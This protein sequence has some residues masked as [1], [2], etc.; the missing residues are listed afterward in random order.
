[1]DL[2][3]ARRIV[4]EWLEEWKPPDLVPREAQ[5]PDLKKL[6]EILAIV[7]PRRAGKTYFMFQMLEDLVR[8]SVCARDDI[9]FIDFEDY[10]LADMTPAD[11]DLLF[12]AFNQLAGKPPRF[13]F[14]D[15]IQRLPSWSRVL[16]ALHNQRRYKIIVSGS[17]SEL[18]G[19]EVSTE[20]RGRY[21]DLL[22]LPFSFREICRFRRIRYTPRTFHTAERGQIIKA[23][24]DYAREGGFPELLHKSDATEK[25]K[26]LQNYYQTVFYRDILER[27]AVKARPLLEALMRYCVNTYA[28]LFS[29]SAFAKHWERQGWPGSKRTIAAYLYYLEEA[30]FLIAHAKYSYSPRKRI[31]NPKKIYLLDPGFSCL[32]TQFSDNRGKIL[33]NVV[34]VELYRKQ[35][36]AFYHKGRKECDFIVLA[37]GKPDEAIQACWELNDRNENREYS[38]LLEAMKSFQI[39]KGT[40]LTYNQESA[41]RLLGRDIEIF[42]VWKWLLS[43]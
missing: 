9:L 42:P 37:N 31:M 36:E 12:V 26:L 8:R 28:E 23:F 6:S 2:E 15:E 27:H 14:F 43:N 13:L 19:S 3:A 24:D 7:G 16:R 34:A 38:G 20:L 40:I 33:E 29:V 17:N 25:R 5:P 32:A 41:R 10:R 4:A 39:R 30:F 18:L 11:I 35:R 21:R 22:I 1:M